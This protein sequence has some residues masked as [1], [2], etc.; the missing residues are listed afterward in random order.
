MMLR[1]E[2]VSV[3][4]GELQVLWDISFEVSEGEIV[5]LVGANAAGKTTILKTIAGLVRPTRGRVVFDGKDLG[6]MQSHDIVTEGLCLIPEGRRLFPEMTVRE[7]LRAWGVWHQSLE[8]QGR[9]PGTLVQDLPCS[10]GKGESSW[11]EL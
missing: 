9:S 7:N 2:A 5:A 3:V 4:F 11:R 6:G 1:L 10:S 8:R